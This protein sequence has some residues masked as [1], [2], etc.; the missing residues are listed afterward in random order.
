MLD[1][2]Q[3]AGVK[4]VILTPT[5]HN[6][7]EPDGPTNRKAAAYVDFLRQTALERKPPLADVNAAHRAEIAR[8]N[9]DDDPIHARHAGQNRV[10]ARIQREARDA[11]GRESAN[12]APAA[13]AANVRARSKTR[14][15]VY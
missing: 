10:R 15:G 4:V 2:S 1:M 13:I 12:Q 6:E 9:G 7:A 3:A 5:L 11:F 8:L 14:P